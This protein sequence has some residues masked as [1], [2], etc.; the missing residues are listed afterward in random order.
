MNSYLMATWENI[1]FLMKI[2]NSLYINTWY[3]ISLHELWKKN[4]IPNENINWIFWGRKK[5]IFL[6]IH[7]IGFSYTLKLNQNLVN[8]SFLISPQICQKFNY[9]SYRLLILMKSGKK[10]VAQFFSSSSLNS[11]NLEIQLLNSKQD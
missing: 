7:E 6:F 3:A 5:N 4:P 2:W 9:I 1:F 11:W 10:N 8:Q